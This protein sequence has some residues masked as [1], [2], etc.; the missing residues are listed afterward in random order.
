MTSRTSSAKTLRGKDEVQSRLAAAW[1]RTIAGMGGK[2]ATFAE[3]IGCHPDTVSNALAGNTVP[4]LHTALN[5]LA[6]CPEALYEV[7]SLYGFR[8]VPDDMQMSPDMLVVLEMSEA[9]TCYIAALQDGRR[10]HRETIQIA[11]K[12]RPL[13]AK[14]TALVAEADEKRGLKAVA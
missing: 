7:F 14:L 6:V 10:D 9:L 3:A 12:V 13:I 11:E 2:K 5:S 8:L 1:A 4:E